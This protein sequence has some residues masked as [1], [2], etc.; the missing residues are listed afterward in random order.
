MNNKKTLE[1]AL[2]RKAP[3]TG[4]KLYDPDVVVPYV[5]EK[6][7]E[8]VSLTEIC[9][10]DDVPSLFHTLR[11]INSKDSWSLAYKKIREIRAEVEFEKML[12][13]VDE[14]P[15]DWKT[16][17]VKVDTRKWWIEHALQPSI[18]TKE[19]SDKDKAKRLINIDLSPEALDKL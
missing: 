11:L 1:Q 5:F 3:N 12:E 15:S 17:K 16:A 14:L 8:G 4:L 9:K 6:L 13:I 10:E 18:G 2:A 7:G 19:E